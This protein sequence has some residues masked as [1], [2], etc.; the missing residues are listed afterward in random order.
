M[1]DRE[2]F[3]TVR[4][5]NLS[6]VTDPGVSNDSSAGYGPGSIWINTVLGR[7]WGCVS[8][9]V[10]AAVWSFDGV[11]PTT[12]VE[13]SGMQVQFGGCVVAAPLTPF[14]YFFEEGNIYR[15]CGNPIAGNGADNTD[16]ILDGFVL[17]AN[18]FDKANRQLLINFNGKFATNGN[19]KRVKVWLNPAMSGQTVTGGVISG[20]TVTGVG[21]G[22]LL[23]DSG[24]QTGSNIGW[25]V[26]CILC[27]YGALGSNTQFNQNSAIYGSTH[28]G[29]S[30]PAFT[31]IPENAAINIVVT[32]GSPTSSAANDVVLSY[33][34]VNAMN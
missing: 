5:H 24:T 4:V 29:T 10:G 9:A 28:S 12:G 33:T 31:T 18:A 19:N 14:S 2:S 21:S 1:A 7:V 8:N 11:V 3:P 34:E 17:P 32:G 13:P 16:D 25:Q 22:V 20:G 26:D 15:N 23:F 6:A 27:K 30:L